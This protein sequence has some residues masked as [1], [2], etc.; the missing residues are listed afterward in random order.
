[1][2]AT[3]PNHLHSL[4]AFAQL[5]DHTLLKAEATPA[6][7][8][9]LCAEAERHGFK[10]VC[11]NPVYVALAARELRSQKVLPI[12]VIGFPLGANRT[13]VK[14]DETLRAV[15][16]GAREVDMVIGVGLYLSG[17]RSAVRHDIAA[18][19]RAAGNVPV[20]VILETG[21]LTTAQIEELTWWC[22]EAG[23]AFVKTSTGF[24]PRGAN[25]D[26]VRT[27]ARAMTMT[28]G[29]IGIKASGGVRK[30][31]DVLAL[32]AA[33]ATRIGSSATVRI[34]REFEEARAVSGPY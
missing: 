34:L 30:L 23:A 13:D 26:D 33:G 32:V 17:E 19:V 20:K 3:L 12:T 16:D 14:I 25:V 5:F 24:G 8:R 27:M 22:V 28:Q 9:H 4:A 18:V 1:M 6:D 10:A 7:V 29:T 11:V 2:L 31:G 21:Y 15:G